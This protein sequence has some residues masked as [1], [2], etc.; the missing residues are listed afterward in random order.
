MAVVGPNGM[1][2]ARQENKGGVPFVF[3]K[4]RARKGLGEKNEKSTV[5]RVNRSLA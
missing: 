4:V 2:K 3:L 1:V 5:M